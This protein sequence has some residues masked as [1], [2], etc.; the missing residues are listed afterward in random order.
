M[1]ANGKAMNGNGNALTGNTGAASGMASL[2]KFEHIVRKTSPGYS[3]DTR[4]LD[5]LDQYAEYIKGLTGH[6]PPKDEVVEKALQHIFASD[7]GFKR[8]LTSGSVGRSLASAKKNQSG[9][10]ATASVESEPAVTGKVAAQNA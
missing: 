4:V 5:Q 3:L 1:S 8:Y 9:P 7:A 6:A 2:L 10:T